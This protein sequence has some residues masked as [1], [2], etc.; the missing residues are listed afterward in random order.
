MLLS[1]CLWVFLDSFSLCLS[2]IFSCLSF[3]IS[4]SL[5]VYS[6]LTKSPPATFPST[7]FAPPHWP[8]CWSS[9]MPRSFLPQHLGACFFLCLNAFTSSLLLDHFLTSSSSLFNI[10]SSL[11]ISS[12]M[13]LSHPINNCII[14]HCYVFIM[15]HGIYLNDPVFLFFYLFRTGILPSPVFRTV[16]GTEEMLNGYLL[17][18]CSYSVVLIGSSSTPP[19]C[20]VTHCSGNRKDVISS[21]PCP[22]SHLLVE[23]LSVV[24]R[25]NAVDLSLVLT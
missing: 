9:N 13:L 2:F 18:E 7:Y 21:F 17:K 25:P 20:P 10:V 23:L 16:P 15:A 12:E 19:S 4:F 24:L 5:C 6:Y 11:T 14:F 22:L 3:S 1:F 8:S